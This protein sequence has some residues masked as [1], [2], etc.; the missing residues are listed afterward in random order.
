MNFVGVQGRWI[1]VEHQGKRIRHRFGTV[2]PGY[3]HLGFIR[4]GDQSFNKVY[5]LSKEASAAEAL[6][7]RLGK[8]YRPFEVDSG[9]FA[10]F[11]TSNVV[12]HGFMVEWWIRVFTDRSIGKAGMCRLTPSDVSYI[13]NTILKTEIDMGKVLLTR[14]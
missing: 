2:F 14:V 9:V 6:L 10:S 12:V 3:V 1:I 5:L 4:I 8:Y 11:E 13:E 7:T